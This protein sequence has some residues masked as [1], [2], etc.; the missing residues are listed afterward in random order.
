LVPA[1]SNRAALVRFDGVAEMTLHGRKC[2]E[3]ASR[4]IPLWNG[5]LEQKHFQKIGAA[6]W[7]YVW[8][9]DRITAEADGEGTLLGG[10][11]IKASEIAD[12]YGMDERSV[13][14]HLDRLRRG[15]YIHVKHA[16]YGLLITVL[17][18]M[19]FGI[20]KPS[21]RSDR[22]TRPDGER[23]EKIPGEV[24]K[25]VPRGRKEPSDVIKTQQTQY[26]HAAAAAGENVWSFLGIAPCGNPEFQTLLESCWQSKNGETPSLVIGRCLDAW[27]DVSGPGDQWKKGLPQVFRAVANLRK[28]ERS[29]TLTPGARAFAGS[30]P[31]AVQQCRQMTPKGRA[32]Y[33][34]LGIAVPEPEEVMST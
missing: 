22:N 34:D 26:K 12:T 18:S 24:G 5:L 14:N 10:R 1:P 31:A 30:D 13:R 23:S 7:V 15:G 6:L 25:K 32:R 11:P 4:P 27:R 16:P 21:N 29:Q 2:G 3:K 33:K 28:N 20:W 9:L 17:N 19:K 8:L